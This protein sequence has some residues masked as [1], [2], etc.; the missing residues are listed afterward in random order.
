[1]NDEFPGFLAYAS[2][3]RFTARMSLIDAPLVRTFAHEL[4][5][6]QAFRA[7]GGHWVPQYFL[8]SHGLMMNRLYSG[9][10]G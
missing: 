7:L 9:H 3:N 4:A 2:G 10:I 6:V 5:H 1:M 8:G